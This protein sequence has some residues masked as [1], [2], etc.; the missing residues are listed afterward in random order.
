MEE[1]VNGWVCKL[2]HMGVD[3]SDFFGLLWVWGS[4]SIKI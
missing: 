2:V 3:G 1:I 4:D